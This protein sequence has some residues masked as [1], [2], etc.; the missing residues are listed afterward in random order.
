MKQLITGSHCSSLVANVVAVVFLFFSRRSCYWIIAVAVATSAS[1][2]VVIVRIS[3]V[4]ASVVEE[5]LLWC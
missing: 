4:V 3:S 1:T 2:N 5:V